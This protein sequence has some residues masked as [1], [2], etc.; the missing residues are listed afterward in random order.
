MSRTYGPK[1]LLYEFRELYLELGETHYQGEKVQNQIPSWDVGGK[2]ACPI[3]NAAAVDRLGEHIPNHSYSWVGPKRY[4][5]FTVTHG[6]GRILVS[7]LRTS[8]S[9][10]DPLAARFLRNIVAWSAARK[11]AD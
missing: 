2:P 9:A 1:C 5:V 4:A 8:A 7:E 10:S 3:H 11:G 6:K